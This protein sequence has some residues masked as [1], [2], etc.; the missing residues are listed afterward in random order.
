[1]LN[2]VNVTNVHETTVCGVSER[3]PGTVCEQLQCQTVIQSD[4][5]SALVSPSGGSVLVRL[6]CRSLGNCFHP[7]L[8][9]FYRRDSKPGLFYL[10][11]MPGKLTIPSSAWR[12]VE[13][14]DSMTDSSTNGCWSYNGWRRWRI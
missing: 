9:V 14:P 4:W 8:P 5:V 12:E 11:W 1:V 6:L 2:T 7:K 10:N 13:K 3:T